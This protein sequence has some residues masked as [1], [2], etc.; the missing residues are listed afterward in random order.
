MPP[1]QMSPTSS[2]SSAH[3]SSFGVAVLPSEPGHRL[4]FGAERD[5]L[6]LARE[7]PAA[8]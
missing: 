6:E 2:L 3:M 1:N 5:G 7:D 4:H 8:G